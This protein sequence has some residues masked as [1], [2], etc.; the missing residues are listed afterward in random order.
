MG[1][2]TA[3]SFRIVLLIENGSVNAKLRRSDLLI[4]LINI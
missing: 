3:S 4:Y 1:L 2:N